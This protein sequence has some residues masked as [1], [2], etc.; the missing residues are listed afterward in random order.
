MSSE[1]SQ[2][3]QAL[4]RNS[5]R[6]AMEMIDLS[7]ALGELGRVARDPCIIESCMVKAKKAYGTALTKGRRTFTVME[8]SD[9]EYK[10]SRAETLIAELESRLKNQPIMRPADGSLDF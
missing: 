10:S 1:T 7:I 2:L 3:L 8:C 4:R 6:W 9:F 5:T